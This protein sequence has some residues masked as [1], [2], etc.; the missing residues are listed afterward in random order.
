[1]Q[2]VG[3]GQPVLLSEIITAACEVAGVAD[4]PISSV[5]I[6]GSGANLQPSAIQA[7]RLANLAAVTIVASTVTY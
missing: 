4:V 2:G 1:V 3:I 5:Q 6:N 7:P